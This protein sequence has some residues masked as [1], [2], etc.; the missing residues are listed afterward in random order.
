M[1]KGVKKVGD[2]KAIQLRLWR[3]VLIAESILDSSESTTDVKLKAIH[4]LIQLS[5]QYIKVC[6]EV[7]YESNRGGAPFKLEEDSFLN[8]KL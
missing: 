8:F 3:S 7:R 2:I 6:N 1:I 4:C 5:G